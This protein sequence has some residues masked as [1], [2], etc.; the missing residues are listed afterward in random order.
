[1]SAI[2]ALKAEFKKTSCNNALI[3]DVLRSFHCEEWKYYKKMMV[4]QQFSPDLL[5]MQEANEVFT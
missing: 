5:L 2:Q 3:S 4:L 1:M